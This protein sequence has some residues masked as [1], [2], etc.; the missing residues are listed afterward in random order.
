VPPAEE[1]GLAVKK[2][3]LI[4]AE[5]D[6]PDV[7]EHRRNF[8]IARRF[9][10][11]GSFVFL[12]ESGAKTNMTRLYGRAMGGERCVDRTPHGHWGS[13]TMVSA[14]RDRG[15]LEQASVVLD[16]SMDGPTFLTYVEQCLVPALRPGDVVVMDNLR[17]HKVAG[18][19]EA[20]EQAGCDLWYLPAYSPDF[21]PIE[22]L[23]SKVKAWL[24]RVGAKTFE[25]V[26][27]AVGDALRAVDSD[28]CRNYFA[29]CGY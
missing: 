14:I 15:V 18:V 17:S 8:A 5:Q 12:D 29:S 25:T 3:S 10:A 21:N 22:K 9:V 1:V 2:K 26:S 23:W 27:A 24:R 16:G 11:G 7:A 13:M 19:R 20:I 4:A 6:R 28:E